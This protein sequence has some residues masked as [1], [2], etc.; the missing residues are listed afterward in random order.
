MIVVDNKYNFGDIVFLKTDIEQ[1][2]RI[3]TAIIFCPASDI[4][5]EV[6]CGTVVS[7]HYDFEITVS[8]EVII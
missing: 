3:I 7:R 8:K 6:T 4:L 5:Y 1:M 2:P